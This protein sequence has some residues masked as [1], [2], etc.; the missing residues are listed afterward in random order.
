[1]GIEGVIPP[2]QEGG[3]QDAVTA[4]APA[5]EALT[6]PT[7]PKTVLVAPVAFAAIGLFEF[8]VSGTPVIF[9]PR[10]SVTVAFRVVVVLVFTTKEVAGLPRA[11]I[12]ID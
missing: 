2:L 12:E 10:M 1:M 4:A 3:V 11:L 7:L 9:M 5:A 6:V 8:Q